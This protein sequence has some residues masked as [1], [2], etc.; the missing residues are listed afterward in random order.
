[1][2]LNGTVGDVSIRFD[3]GYSIKG[4][5]FSES[6]VKDW[7]NVDKGLDFMLA[8]PENMGLKQP[9]WTHTPP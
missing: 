8:L 4:S 3:V 6:L 9:Y 5:R 1:M 2:C 7:F